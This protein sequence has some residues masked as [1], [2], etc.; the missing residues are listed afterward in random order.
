MAANGAT[1]V[2]AFRFSGSRPVAGSWQLFRQL[3]NSEWM[4]VRGGWTNATF[5]EG[6]VC[7]VDTESFPPTYYVAQDALWVS[8]DE[9]LRWL[10]YDSGLPR[11]VHPSDLRI[12]PGRSGR[13]ERTLSLGTFGWSLWETAVPA[14][15]QRVTGHS[16]NFYPV[17]EGRRGSL[18]LNVGRGDRLEQFRFDNNVSSPA[19]RRGP[20]RQPRVKA[21]VWK[22]CSRWTSGPSAAT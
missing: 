11:G 15:S 18:V 6:M 14:D 7:E 3:P 1:F 16:G 8:H 9:G 10:R 12:G 19:W 22:G 2:T 4:A 5:P 13:A 17:P 20:L 21:A